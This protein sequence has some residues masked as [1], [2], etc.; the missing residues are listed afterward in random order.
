MS[1]SRESNRFTPAHIPGRNFLAMQRDEFDAQR[2]AIDRQTFRDW[3]E[4]RHRDEDE[5]EPSGTCEA[6]EAIGR[7]LRFLADGLECGNLPQ[8]ACAMLLVVRPDLVRGATYPALAAELGVSCETIKKAVRHL[9]EEF[10]G[11]YGGYRRSTIPEREA[12]LYRQRRAEAI[13]MHRR[14]RAARIRKARAAE[15][16]ARTMEQRALLARLALEQEVKRE[17][18]KAAEEMREFDRRLGLI[19][20]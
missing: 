17:R 15:A 3:Q 13:E 8:R 10:P 12:S 14:V 16:L 11:I 18:A 7:V 20:V 5:A 19:P 1:A 2:Y 9:R 4:R 6:T